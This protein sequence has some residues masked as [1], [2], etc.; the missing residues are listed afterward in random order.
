MSASED[1][2]LLDD[3]TEQIDQLKIDNED[4]EF[5]LDQ[6]RNEKAQLESEVEDNNEFLRWLGN[7]R[8]ETRMYIDC[9]YAMYRKKA[10]KQ[11]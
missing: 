1:K 2:Q 7:E 8:F 5:E 9:L 10:D 3:L 6:L 11:I 4:L